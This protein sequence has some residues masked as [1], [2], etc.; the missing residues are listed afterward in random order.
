MAQKK[1]IA[2]VV[3]A[4]AEPVA[5]QLGL[6]LWDVRYEK[7]G[8]SWFLRIAVDK[9]G[10]IT[11]DDCERMSRA[12][13]P[14]LDEKDPI[15]E[16]YYLEVSSPGLERELTRPEHF[17]LM[18]G[19]PIQL[20]LIRP[21]NGQRDFAG[22]LAGFQDNTIRLQTEEKTAEFFLKDTAFVK[23]DDLNH[24]PEGISS[25]RNIGEYDH[26]GE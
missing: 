8:A 18:M 2:A 26:Q 7:E 25:E 17:E 15:P 23:L 4:L 3:R 9:E 24:P 16:S 1:N 21:V 13:D 22:I 6:R 10:A 19:R 5:A 12:I 20:R 14:I 11:I